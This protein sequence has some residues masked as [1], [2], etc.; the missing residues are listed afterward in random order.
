MIRLRDWVVPSDLNLSLPRI[1]VVS[2]IAADS[3]LQFGATSM[4]PYLILMVMSILCL[5]GVTRKDFI[6]DSILMHGTK[7]SECLGSDQKSV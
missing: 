2:W 1:Q 5:A 7:C 4:V 3:S 6:R